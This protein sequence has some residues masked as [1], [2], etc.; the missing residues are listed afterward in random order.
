MISTKSAGSTRKVAEAE[1]PPEAVLKVA[2]AG[3]KDVGRSIA[4]IDPEDMARLGASVGDIVEIK[5]KRATVAKVMPTFAG[6]R[7]KSLVQIPALRGGG[8]GRG[9]PVGPDRVPC[10]QNRPGTWYTPWD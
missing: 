2:E 5:G 6:D 9:G 7:G 10:I 4:R 1:K 3:P 8:W